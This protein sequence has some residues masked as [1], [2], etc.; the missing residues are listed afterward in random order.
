MDE[1]LK[2]D[3]AKAYYD[4]KRPKVDF[5]IKDLA[6]YYKHRKFLKYYA[7]DETLSHDLIDLFLLYLDNDQR[8]NRIGL[9]KDILSQLIW[10]KSGS[11]IG[12]KHPKKF[13]V[14]DMSESLKNGVFHLFQRLTTDKWD[15]FFLG[16]PQSAF[17]LLMKLMV[18][19][20]WSAQKWDWIKQ[21]LPHNVHVR[22]L[23]EDITFVV[24]NLHRF[25]S[26]NYHEQF[27]IEN[28]VKYI[29]HLIDADKDFVIDQQT[30]LDDC[31]V[32]NR[33]DQEYIDTVVNDFEQQRLVDQANWDLR[34]N[35]NTKFSNPFDTGEFS[36]IGKMSAE[37]ESSENDDSIWLGPKS[38]SEY[39]FGKPKT[40]FMGYHTP[41]CFLPHHSR[42][43]PVPMKKQ[44]IQQVEFPDF[45]HATE[46]LENSIEKYQA[47]YMVWAIVYSRVPKKFK[48]KMIERWWRED[49]ALTWLHIA[50]RYQ[51]PEI[52]KKHF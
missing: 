35:I 45:A 44:K 24:P 18:R 17:W 16:K 46:I 33:L 27:I 5:E 23:V 22:P 15:Q 12:S 32:L 51:M 31:K 8:L 2:D 21:K 43:Y 48:I 1:Y 25:I 50:K 28:R 38:Y 10:V 14:A 37:Y 42:L 9:L 41:Y 13:I 3:F 39:Y 29:S 30:I 36:N 7:F 26:D 52:L 19:V 40:E 34:H 49:L 4:M 6:A 47:K 20:E 11:D